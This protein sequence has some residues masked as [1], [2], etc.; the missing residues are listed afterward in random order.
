LAAARQIPIDV[1][2]LAPPVGD[3]EVALTG[4]HAPSGIRVGQRFELT[5]AVASTTATSGE[6]RI[7]DDDVLIHQRSVRLT[8][9]LNRVS[10]GA[11]AEVQGF[12][13]YRAQVATAVDTRP[14]NNTA[15]TFG[16]VY[17]PPRI[18]V[19]TQQA[20]EARPLVSAL[21]AADLQAVTQDP[22]S[23]PTDLTA[24]AGYD[25]VILDN[26]PFASLPPGGAETLATFVRDLGHGLIMIGGDQSFG[27][28]GYLRTPIEAALPVAMDVRSRTEE[29]NVALVMALDK[30]GS[31]GR[32]HCDDPDGPSVRTE[33]GIPKVD[34]AKQAMIEASSLLSDFDYLGVL[35]FDEQARWALETQPRVNLTTLDSV[36]AG[37]GADGGTNIMSGLDQAFRSLQQV[38]ARTKHIILIT[39]GWTNAGGYDTLVNQMHDRG[40][41]LSIVAAGRGSAT[42]LQQLTEA[43]GGKYYPVT[44]MDEVPRVFL[45]E[46]VRTIGRLIVEAPVRPQ[47]GS[48]SQV[49]ADIDM[50]GVPALRGYNGTTAKAAAVIPL[51]APEGEPLLAHWQYGLGRSVAWTSDLTG[52]WAVD[53]LT[54]P[55]Y[56]TFVAQMASWTLPAPQSSALDTDA[57]WDGES[58]TIRV[59]AVDAAGQP[60]TVDGLT[61]QIIGPDLETTDVELIPTA[62][63]RYQGEVP[64]AETGSY[65]VRVQETHNGVPINAQT[66][67][68]VA[69]YSPEYTALTVDTAFLMNAASAT[70]GR[71][72]IEPSEAF[73]PVSQK[74]QRSRPIWTWLLLGSLLLFPLDVAT[75][76]LYLSRDDIRT[77]ATVIARRLGR[78]T[79]DAAEEPLLGDLFV[80]KERAERRTRRDD[81]QPPRQS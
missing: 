24:L 43:G 3:A 45:Q 17:G 49:L 7:W 70:G 55:G 2:P 20:N 11:T 48:P 74:A 32:C 73:D 77:A 51:T 34:I 15:S 65:L 33:V 13:R 80:A 79:E 18:L 60:R 5:A 47:V 1:V 30:S 44:T 31:M 6:I 78:H 37:F 46:T 38:E 54:W 58:A 66:S 50:T 10:T 41:T 26:V 81:R 75:R 57:R 9:G 21:R 76:R 4:L 12:H 63:G 19:V 69:P 25:T 71:L 39:D 14:Q 16:V 52:R 72:T 27:A 56:S 42:Y 68:F 61:A 36:V 29:P 35:A 8:P 23:L 64:V 62:V 28:G 22:S 59:D 67:G 53:W 40:I